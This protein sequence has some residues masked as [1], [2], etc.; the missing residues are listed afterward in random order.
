MK[1]KTQ[2]RLGRTQCLRRL[3]T[4]IKVTGL[5][6]RL[7]S[8]RCESALLTAESASLSLVA[9]YCE[10]SARSVDRFATKHRDRR[11]SRRREP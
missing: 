3:A 1:R 2:K 11:G 5:K 10:K 8:Q 9:E 6:L 4:Q 7:L